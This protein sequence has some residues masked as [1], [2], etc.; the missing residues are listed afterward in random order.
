MK[1][2]YILRYTDNDANFNRSDCCNPIPGDDVMGFVEEDNTVTVHAL[3]CP[4]AAMLKASYGPRIVAT[5]WAVQSGTFLA[6]IRIEGIDRLGI[7]Q[8]LI[9]VI[10]TNMSLN[11]RKLNIAA[12]KEVFHC[13]LTVLVEDTEIVTDLCNKVK[14]INGVQRAARVY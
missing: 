4:R 1:E 5:R 9:S 14:K 7:L 10:S 6:S 3:T 8:E 13:D 2:T 11:I 12:D